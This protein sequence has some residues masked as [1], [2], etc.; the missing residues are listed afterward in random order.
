[1]RPHYL[2][3]GEEDRSDPNVF[4]RTTDRVHNENH[5]PQNYRI[6]SPLYTRF[7]RGERPASK[8]Q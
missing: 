6:L 3:H 4:K 1:M 5:R 7:A 2:S 8:K